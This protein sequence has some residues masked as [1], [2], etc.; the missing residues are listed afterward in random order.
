MK[1]I[2]FILVCMAIST[3]LACGDHEATLLRSSTPLIHSSLQITHKNL[4]K[5]FPDLNLSYDNSNP[6]HRGI[7]TWATD[8]L[9][10][11]ATYALTY[12]DGPHP[13]NTP[14]LLNILKQYNVTATFF[15][16][17]HLAVKYP[18]IIKR[19]IS[20]GHT[21]A[22]HDWRHDNSNNETRDQFKKGLKDSLLAIKSYSKARETYYR[23]PYGAYANASDY[24][25]FNVI[26][27]VSQE[28]FSENCINFAFW[29]IDTSDWVS[30]M[31]P[32]NINETFW[33]NHR[34]GKA[35]RFKLS[36]GRYVKEPYTI[37]NPRNGGVVLMHDIHKRTVDATELI[38][39]SASTQN[40]DFVLL[41]DV[42]EFSYSN[43]TC[44][45]VL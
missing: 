37:S 4:M 45:I 28:L 17:G 33:A 13:T 30:G 3:T 11:K 25:H 18:K 44:E 36:S 41:K 1:P 32:A 35:W 43:K 7:F 34:G 2:V 29:E 20:E 16:M 40:V 10:N 12:D 5:Q 39:K 15:V 42:E 14:R 27:E 8:S 9:K 24:H 23:F 26:K 21:V 19:M 38:L 6:N 22:S 31:S